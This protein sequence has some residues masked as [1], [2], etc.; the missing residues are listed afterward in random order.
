[1]MSPQDAQAYCKEVSQKSGSNFYYSFL[2]LP[3][4][5]RELMYTIYAFCREVD[6]AVDEPPTGSNPHE[7]V[8]HWREEVEAAYMDRAKFPVTVSLSHHLKQVDIPQEYFQ[9]LI[10]GV[11]MDLTIRRYE[12]FQDLYAYCYRVASVVG[13]I[14]LKVFGTRSEKADAYAINLGMAFQL[15]NI[16]RDIGTDAQNNRIYLPQEDFVRFGYSEQ[17]LFTHKHNPAF[18]EFMKFQCTRAREYYAKARQ[19]LQTL[20]V[21]DRRSLIVAEIMRGVYGRILD[22]IEAKNY[23]VFDERVSLH[24]FNRLLIA[25]KIWLRSSISGTIT[26]QA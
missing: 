2:F 24:S 6:N 1:M 22:Q 11:E 10:S 12:T 23:Q 9:E 16:L 8:A 4:A 26:Q 7:Q 19:I 20:P 5:R 15:T 17:D 3:H 21:S 25:A 14:C 13:L 18:I